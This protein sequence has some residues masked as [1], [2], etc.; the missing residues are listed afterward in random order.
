M[1]WVQLILALIPVVREVPE[2]LDLLTNMRDSGQD[3]PTPEQI[4]ALDAAFKERQIADERWDN[5]KAA[6][7]SKRGRPKKK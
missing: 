4:A 2:F 6:L 7:K 3:E 5:I 1:P